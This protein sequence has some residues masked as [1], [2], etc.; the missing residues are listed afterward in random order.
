MA[1]RDEYYLIIPK[2]VYENK[3]ISI[4]DIED[5]YFS[6]TARMA[7]ERGDDS[8]TIKEFKEGTAIVSKLI[9]KETE[10]RSAYYAQKDNARKIISQ[11]ITNNKEQFNLVRHQIEDLLFYHLQI[12]S[13]PAAFE[14]GSV[15]GEFDL[16]EKEVKLLGNGVIVAKNGN[17]IMG[18][19]PI[20]DAEN[21]TTEYTFR[22]EQ[23]RSD[24]HPREIIEIVEEPHISAELKLLAEELVNSALVK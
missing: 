12:E 9:P 8:D 23:V 24:Y 11:Y 6:L 18:V 21:L 13:T 4:Y 22:W 5:T 2:A 16:I 7:W 3:S 1:K 14:K 17:S 15:L 10:L 19:Y 20:K